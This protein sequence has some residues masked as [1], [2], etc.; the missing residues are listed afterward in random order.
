VSH[1]PY[2]AYCIGNGEKYSV[3][4][5][6]RSGVEAS[7]MAVEALLEQQGSWALLALSVS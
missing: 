1:K 5:C 6:H 3:K 2:G 7:T 4:A